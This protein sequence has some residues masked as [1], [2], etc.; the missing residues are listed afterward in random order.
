MKINEYG[1]LETNIA[2]IHVNNCIKTNEDISFVLE[3]KVYPK[4]EFHHEDDTRLILKLRHKEIRKI[5]V[6]KCNKHFNFLP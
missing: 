5:I 6:F 2:A 4:D 3:K 1:H